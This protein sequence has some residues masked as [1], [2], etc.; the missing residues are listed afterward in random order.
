V[1][2]AGEY[3]V[4]FDGAALLLLE[5]WQR[6]TVVVTVLRGRDGHEHDHGFAAAA[7]R[8]QPSD[9]RLLIAD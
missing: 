6:R 8:R 5:L 9:C 1:F 3:L 7:G 2:E 4:A